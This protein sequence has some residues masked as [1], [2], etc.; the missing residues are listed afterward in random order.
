MVNKER[1]NLCFSYTFWKRKVILYLRYSKMRLRIFRQ[2]DFQHTLMMNTNRCTINWNK[3]GSNLRKRRRMSKKV[4]LELREMLS[5][6]LHHSQIECTHT[7]H[8]ELMC[9]ELILVEILV[10]R[11]HS[12][13][14]PTWVTATM[15]LSR[16]KEQHRSK[17][18]R[19]CLN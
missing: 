9:K 15:Y 1:T 11:F 4:D 7:C 19:L 17:D 6:P 13:L 16:L 10:N 3:K 8:L 12:Y 5:L 14:K 2:L 18:L